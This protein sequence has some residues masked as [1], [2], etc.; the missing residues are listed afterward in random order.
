MKI[1]LCLNSWNKLAWWIA[2]TTLV[3]AMLS[4]TALY[5][6]MMAWTAAPFL[7][8][9]GYYLQSYCI[10]KNMISPQNPSK[11]SLEELIASPKIIAQNDYNLCGPASILYALLYARPDDFRHFAR[12]FREDPRNVGLSLPTRTRKEFDNLPIDLAIMMALKHKFNL[13]GYHP[14]S[15]SIEKIQGASFPKQMVQFM[16][17]FENYLG[18]TT[19]LPEENRRIIETTTLQN[20]YGQPLASYHQA[21]L[22]G[23]YSKKHY[24]PP[25][26]SNHINYLHD[27]SQSKASIM[28]LID[29]NLCQR[30]L[31]NDSSKIKDS[32]AGVE[33]SH[34]VYLNNISFNKFRNTIT[35]KISTWGVCAERTLPYDTFAEGFRGFIAWEGLPRLRYTPPPD[36]LSTCNWAHKVNNPSTLF[37]FQE[38]Q[39]KI[40]KKEYH[41]EAMCRLCRC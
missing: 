40:T 34:Y 23:V 35:I 7:F 13:T 11:A 4:V 38:T 14:T 39:T 31:G 8:L 16:L 3:L 6:S 17:F 5:L 32:L 20:S 22:G 19:T 28:M 41:E 10:H 26:L 37:S 29:M 24:T 9:L 33:L 27:W 21:L 18:I 36:D 12:S 25:N 15:R 2:Y 1:P 30:I